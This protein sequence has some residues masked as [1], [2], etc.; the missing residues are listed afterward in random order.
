[1]MCSTFEC[2]K[3]QQGASTILF[4]YLGADYVGV[5]SVWKFIELHMNDMCSLLLSRKFKKVVS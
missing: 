3:V 1:M 2:K 4:L 5:L